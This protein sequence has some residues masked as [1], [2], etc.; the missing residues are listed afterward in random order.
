MNLGDGA[1]ATG[2]RGWTITSGWGPLV[3]VAIHDGH[4]VRPD[5]APLLALTPA[6]RLREE[7]PWTAL[8]TRIVPTR[9]VVHRSR[10]EVD[11]NRPRGGRVY[12]ATDQG[13]GL[14]AWRGPPAPELVERSREVHDA[15][16]SDM[17]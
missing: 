9:V 12:R 15:F 7:D 1:P 5:V 3:A 2:G 8:W 6:E 13:R 10:F 17:R 11:L 4:L 16:Y 14:G